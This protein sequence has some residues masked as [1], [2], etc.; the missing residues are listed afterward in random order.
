MTGGVVA[1]RIDFAGFAPASPAEALAAGVQPGLRPLPEAPAGSVAAAAVAPAPEAVAAVPAGLAAPLA[2][3]AV[4]PAPAVPAKAPPRFVGGALRFMEVP[5]RY[6]VE[7]D[8]ITYEAIPLRRPSAAEV[9]AYFEAL[10]SIG[11]EEWLHFPIYQHA[12]GTPI[13]P[14][15][16]EHLDPDD[17][18]AVQEASA[19]FLC[20]RLRRLQ[21]A[22]RESSTP[23]TSADTGPTSSK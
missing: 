18:D 8:G 21:E 16:I 7:F 14:E 10:A 23:L 22:S 13:P 11:P 4:A 1:P 12:D 17:F 19:D 20:A 3:P 9:R 2:A 6:P 15:V 5:L